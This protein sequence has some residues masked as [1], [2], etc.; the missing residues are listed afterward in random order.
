VRRIVA[1]SAGLAAL[2]GGSAAARPNEPFTE[3]PVA[4]LVSCDM[5]GV[6]R[7]AVFY[8]RMAG[9][10]PADR[11]AMRFTLYERL[12]R[13]GDW[14]KVDVPDLH[15][16][17]RSAQGVKTF[18]YRQTVGNLRGGAAYKARIQFRT[19]AADGTTIDTT[20]RETPVCRGPLPN[21]A[22]GGLEVR[23]GPRADMRTYRVTVV[24]NGKGDADGIDVALEVDRT[25]LDT[26][27]LDRL[28]AGTGRIVTIVGPACDRTVRVKLDP[29]DKI[30]EVTKTDNVQQFVCPG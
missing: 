25:A 22:V 2:S 3:L 20:T 1:I 6:D 4:R 12:G 9:L 21:L 17:R 5:R 7:T 24:N 29:D 23:R 13:G 14:T 10:P 18:G 30:G 16:W 28:D 19:L 8:G 26:V 27:V 11:L 15:V